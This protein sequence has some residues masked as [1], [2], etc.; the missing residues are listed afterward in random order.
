MAIDETGPQPD[1]QERARQLRREGMSVKQIVAELGLTSTHIVQGWVQGVP[2]PGMDPT[3]SREGRGKRR[4][5]GSS[6]ARAAPMTRSPR[7]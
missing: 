1:I 7:S 2:P 3:A 5:P 6:A 4:E